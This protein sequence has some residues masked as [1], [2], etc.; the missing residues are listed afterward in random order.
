MA[1]RSLL[2]LVVSG[3]FAWISLYQATHRLVA[4]DDPILPYVPG[5]VGVIASVRPAKILKSKDYHELEK[6]GG[7]VIKKIVG[8]MA[9]SYYKLSLS[10]LDQIEQIIIAG[11]PPTKRED[12]GKP[13]TYDLTIIK[14]VRDSKDK[15]ELASH[16]VSETLQYKGTEYFKAKRTVQGFSGY[17]WIADERTIVLTNWQN[18]IK[19][20][21]D[22]GKKD[23]TDAQWFASW[24][25]VHDKHCSILIEQKMFKLAADQYDHIISTLPIDFSVLS[26]IHHVVGE[27]NVGLETEIDIRATCLSSAD[28]I[29]VSEFAEQGLELMWQGIQNSKSAI[30]SPGP[31]GFTTIFGDMIQST[32]VK[33]QGKQVVVNAKFKLDLEKLKPM[34]ESTYLAF[35]RSEGSNNLRQ[36]A[37]GF[38]D[39]H[40]ANNGFLSSVYVSE[41]GKKYSWRIEILPY[42]G[43]KDLYDQY[44]FDEEWNSPHNQKVTSRMPDFFR[45]DSDDQDTTNTSWFLLIGPDGAIKPDGPRNIY[46][47]SNAD[48]TSKT[49]IAI[50]A[51]RDMHWAKP[52]DILVDQK[53]GMPMLGGFHEGGFHVAFA[54]ASV[55]FIDEKIDPKVVWSLFTFDG[56]ERINTQDLRNN[57]D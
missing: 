46:E 7:E 47:I 36:I 18:G 22:H 37:V 38:H 11:N 44:R 5:E 41:H 52:E 30:G 12:L 8:R 20:A 21:I 45:S 29:K 9:D 10:E 39:Y 43:E 27:A 4:Q 54:D 33:R 17:F 26:R 2:R 3:L 28:T 50:E 42:I 56:G 34:F 15:F 25:K 1:R 32:K 53:K 35:K 19:A 55:H 24:K 57:D 49:I 48:G 31:E 40:A 51:K 14:T 23:A 6:A 16:E 13:D